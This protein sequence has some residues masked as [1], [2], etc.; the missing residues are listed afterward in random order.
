M[1]IVTHFSPFI[2][3]QVDSH[4]CSNCLENI[5]SSEAKLRKNKCNTCFD[6][7]SCQSTLSARATSI[8]VPMTTKGEGGD[9]S[10][11][12]SKMVSKKMYYLACLAC[13]WT[14][15][16]VGISDQ[17]SQ[18]CSWPE[19]EYFHNTRFQMLSEHFQAVVLHD[20]QEKQDFLR[21]KTTKTTKFP[22]MT[23]RF[24]SSSLCATPSITLLVLGSHRF[25][26]IIDSS[27]NGL[28]QVIG[29]SE[30]QAKQHHTVSGNFWRRWTARWTIYASN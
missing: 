25:D 13:R 19:Q 27:P 17:A 10:A 21:R 9:E 3:L 24:S 29:K 8:Q 6:C 15:R 20:K 11:E 30:G 23:V 28:R 1:Q 2:Y 7:P 16:D 14:S 26:C 22:S 5:P 12:G 4:F 18:T